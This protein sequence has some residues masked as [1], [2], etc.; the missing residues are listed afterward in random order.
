MATVPMQPEDGRARAEVVDDLIDALRLF[1]VES[2]IFV[3]VFAR[4]HGLGR[5][6]LNAIMWISAG[7]RSGS[8][9]T[10]GELALKLGIGPPATTAL[11]DRLESAGHVQRIRDPR[12]RRKVTVVMQPTALELAVA[13]FSPLGRLMT[14]AVAGTSS[15]DLRRTTAV[16]RRLIGAVTAARDAATRA[17]P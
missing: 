9:M 4:A 15:D 7:T 17:E 13:F 8:P 5:S 6:D 16:V 1:T 12:D 11:V 3:E 10:A 14:D 2:D